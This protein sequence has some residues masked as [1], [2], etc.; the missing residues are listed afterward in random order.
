MIQASPPMN[1]DNTSAPNNALAWGL[2]ALCRAGFEKE[3]AAE[4]DH[5]AQKLGLMGYVRAKEGSA[6]AV[7]ESHE[8]I[9][10]AELLPHCDWQALVFAR[11]LMPWFARV[12]DLPERDRATPIVT[13]VRE[14]GQRFSTALLEHPDSD[15]ARPLSG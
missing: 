2:I 1:S 9:D 14:S 3:T 11:T 12:D 6:F 5:F 13:K 10:L 4:L 15:A 8:G 7:F